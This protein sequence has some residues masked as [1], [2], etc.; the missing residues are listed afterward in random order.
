MKEEI[1]KNE[2]PNKDLCA[3]ETSKENTQTIVHEAETNGT[4][5]EKK[6]KNKKMKKYNAEA[7]LLVNNQ[8]TPIIST[9]PTA[10]SFDQSGTSSPKSSKAVN[11]VS[12]ASPKTKK[13]FEENNSWGSKYIFKHIDRNSSD[14]E[15]ILS[16]F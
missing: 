1:S 3:Q 5:P 2:K 13:L 16:Y 10:L 4:S 11:N 12:G 6:K 8:G 14:F 9:E 7:S 15:D